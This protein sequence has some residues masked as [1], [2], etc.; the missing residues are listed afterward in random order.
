MKLKTI[1]IFLIFLTTL[2]FILGKIE[3][4]PYF[5]IALIL[6]TTFVKGQLLID[7]FMG[8]KDVKLKYRLIVS[9]WLSIVII[10]IGMA[11]LI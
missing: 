6:L 7:F 2:T 9:L 5:F 8:L 10:L 3:L 1:W 11:F 4:S